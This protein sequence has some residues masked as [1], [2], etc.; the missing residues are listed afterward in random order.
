MRC[1]DLQGL[2]AG[3]IAGDLTP[4]QEE[5]SRLHLR[6]CPRCQAA[7]TS[8]QRTQNQLRDLEADYRPELTDRIARAIA[9]HR[10]RRNLLGFLGRG[11]RA[12]GALAMV[13]AVIGL[14]LWQ[15]GPLQKGA[16]PPP[17][18]PVYLL[19]GTELL[20]VELPGR[21]P[22]PVGKVGPGARL[23]DGGLLWDGELL[24][25]LSDRPGGTPE[26]MGTAP[27]SNSD[28]LVASAGGRLRFVW[29]VG[30]VESNS[31]KIQVTPIGTSER[32][33][34]ADL[35]PKEGRAYAAVL[36]PDGSSLYLLAK[37]G[38]NW[39]IKVV[40]TENHALTKAHLLPGGF[41]PH[42]TILLSRDGTRLYVIDLDR[43]MTIDLA[44]STIL[45]DREI[46]EI[47]ATAALS[48][49]G[50]RILAARPG[51]GLTLLDA[52]SGK[53]LRQREGP[54]YR[55]ILWRGPWAYALGAYGLD[56][57]DPARLTVTATSPVPDAASR[58]AIP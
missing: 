28:A 8:L 10:T 2:L 19:A 52:E 53:V 17:A 22:T 4:S 48:P 38:E 32:S 57:I 49:A 30:L 24:Y 34:P 45:L 16:A 36:S 15:R 11:L 20:R 12:A 46:Q 5:F 6:E 42:S 58:I 26:P 37:A 9:R 13:A 21:P 44:R 25:R 35:H 27:H 50:D 43:L 3:L 40:E 55:Q 47:T 39:F 33:F 56:L 1:D 31:Q 7:Y 14:V 51:G 18:E 41:G 29:N 54:Q 23:A